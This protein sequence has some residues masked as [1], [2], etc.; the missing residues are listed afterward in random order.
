MRLSYVHVALP[1]TGRQSQ[2]LGHQP[3][4][5]HSDRNVAHP[6]S[7]TAV[8]TPMQAHQGKKCGWCF[9]LAVVTKKL[10]ADLGEGDGLWL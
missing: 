8:A 9:W 4:Q 7:K 5:P 1:L 2:C 10:R 3:G 6:C